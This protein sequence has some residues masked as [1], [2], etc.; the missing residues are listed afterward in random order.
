MFYTFKNTPF[1]SQTYFIHCMQQNLWNYIQK[2]WRRVWFFPHW[3]VATENE[4]DI[5]VWMVCWNQGRGNMYILALHNTLMA[6]LTV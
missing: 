5:W 4:A 3:S 2:N 6:D 1:L